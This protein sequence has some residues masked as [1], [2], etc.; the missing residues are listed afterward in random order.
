MQVR[1]N[2][3]IIRMLSDGGRSRIYHFHRLFAQ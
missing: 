3:E 1:M 2:R